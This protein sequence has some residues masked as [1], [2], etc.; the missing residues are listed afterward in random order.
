MTNR[1]AAV[2]GFCVLAVAAHAQTRVVQ[3]EWYDGNRREI[4]WMAVDQFATILEPG[5]AARTAAAVE[6]RVRADE[7]K[8]TLIK[9]TGSASFFEVADGREFADHKRA[10]A[11]SPGVA[12][13]S[14]VFYRDAVQPEH[15]M[16]LTGEIIA[17]FTSPR[18]AAALAAFATS[19]G[20]TFVKA[21]AAVPNTFIFDAR[22][23]PDL[24]ALANGM[25]TAPGVAF[26]MPNWIQ[27][28]S[29]R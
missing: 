1:L 19:H 11:G 13:V 26:A 10:L 25:R 21:V 29:R 28:V 24:L 5:A 2:L 12:F 8:A 6:Q 9:R 7:P 18:D 3:R 23:S 22:T 20:V 16:A 27:A 15:A 17:G 14:P 4:V